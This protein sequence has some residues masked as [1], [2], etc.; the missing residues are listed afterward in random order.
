MIFFLG[1]LGGCESD[2][3]LVVH[4]E[5]PA[6]TIQDPNSGAT[7]YAGEEVNFVALVETYDGTDVLEIVHHYNL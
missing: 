5:P 6:V 7:F 3:V 1:M 4:D 2:K